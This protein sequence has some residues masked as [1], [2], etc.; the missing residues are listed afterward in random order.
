MQVAA[1]W[2]IIGLGKGARRAVW[3]AR[4][5]GQW[6]SSGLGKGGGAGTASRETEGRTGKKKMS[7]ML[8]MQGYAS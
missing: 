1:H 7:V 3:L 8:G 2:Y 5:A 4:A 6:V